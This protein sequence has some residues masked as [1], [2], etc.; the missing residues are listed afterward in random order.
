MSKSD[1]ETGEIFCKHFEKV[2]NNIRPIDDSVLEGISQRETMEELGGAPHPLE[3]KNA[4]KKMANRKAA[5]EN[6]IPLE[7]YKYLANAN[8]D[9]FYGIIIDFWTHTNDPE[10]FHTAKLCILPKKGDLKLPKNYRGICLL[11][12]A[13]KVVSLIIAERCQSVL[14]LYGMDEQNGFLHKKG[15]LDASFSLKLALQTRK[16]FGL[17]SWVV[18]VDLVKAFDTVNRDMLM[19]I[20]ARFGL[21]EPLIKVIRCLYKPVR[22]TFKSGKTKYEFINVVGV[23]Q[24]DNLA[25]VLFLFV[26]Q[27]AME[28][29]DN[30]WR[31]HNITT[32]S[33]SWQPEVED[34]P[35]AGTLTGQ[36]PKRTGSLFDFWR[37]LY[38]DDGAFIY[39]SREDMIQ[40]TSLLHAH[41]KRFG[42]LMHTGTRATATRNGSKSKTEAMFFPSDS[43]LREHAQLDDND[44]RSLEEYTKDSWADF[45]LLGVDGEY[46]SFT[47]KFC[48]LGTIISSNLSD[49]AD[50]S[51]RIQQASKA[52][53][54]LSAGVFCNRKY[55]SP[56]IRRRLFMAIVINLLLWGCETWAL[57]KEQH[58]RLES[59]FN[60]W[61][62]AMTGTRWKEIRENRISNKFLR[63]KL[64]NIDSFEEIYATRCF[65]WLEKLADMPATISDSRLPRM[66]LGA[67]CFGGKRV[68]GRPRQNTRRAYLNLV[69]KLKFDKLEIFLGNNKKGELRCI[70]DLIRHNPAEFQLRVDQGTCA[71]VKAWLNSD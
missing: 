7:A 32:P 38:A 31:E 34:E 65:N 36:N 30:V 62:R 59:C 27:A 20:L 33:F 9:H 18:F 55:L 10:E 5:G 54:S 61:I 50:I 8:F 51:R 52:F 22:M 49:D 56:K 6:K 44:S 12:V 37:S 26:M 42:M 23:K 43:T 53:G 24:G 45:D 70:F 67:W 28:T 58:Q 48:Y 57:T 69:D 41:F 15:C 11:D 21:P 66:L 19:T 13:S 14:K 63:E 29:L 39:A 68:N 16:E 2:F 25:P 3:V 1:A 17:D 47:N 46:I 71:F 64:D 35:N 40:G 60:K 4:M